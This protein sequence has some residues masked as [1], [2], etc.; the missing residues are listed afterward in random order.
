MTFPKPL[1][2]ILCASLSMYAAALFSVPP[3]SAAFAEDDTAAPTMASSAAPFCPGSSIIPA[4]TATASVTTAAT[5][6]MT[7][8]PT[9]AATL[10][11][12]TPAATSLATQDAT[13]PLQLTS[14]LPTDIRFNPN[15]EK[16]VALVMVFSLIFRNQQADM[17]HV[18]AP[19]FRLAIDGI[20]W[21][22]LSSTD[23]QTG[24]LSANAEQS[25]VLQSLFITPKANADQQAVLTCL[26]TFQP[27]DLTLSGTINVF[28]GGTKQIISATLLTPGIVVREHQAPAAP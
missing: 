7:T 25:I 21:G 6:I 14:F 12:P 27:V 20:D 22:E 19:R 26:R 13:A 28:P 11:S 17:L 9:A 18:E 4:A 2:L 5:A 3:A 23:F 24:Q 10:L 8:V 1:R 16:P 15:P